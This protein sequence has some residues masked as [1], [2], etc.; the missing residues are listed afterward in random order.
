VKLSL[1]EIGK[2]VSAKNI[3]DLSELLFIE[4]VEFDS[5]KTRKGSLFIPLKGNR[6]GHN[7]IES[8]KE[9]EAAAAFWEI[10]KEEPKDFPV[11]VVD[12]VLSAFQKLASYY[13]EK[14]KPMVIAVTGSNG[15]TTTKDMLASMLSTTFRTYKTQG[16]YNN[17]IGLPYTVLSMPEET[18]KIVLEMG[19][20]HPGDIHLLSTLAKPD[21]AILTL[22]GESHLEFFGTRENIA[23]G[24]FEIT[25]G[26]NGEGVLLYPGDEPLL[27]EL[28]AHLPQAHFS[29]G[30]AEGDR[31][32]YTLLESGKHSSTFQTSFLSQPVTIPFPGEYNVKN[33]VVS[34]FVA[35][36][37][38][39][40]EQAILEDLSNVE[41]TRNRT[42]W[43]TSKA[44]AE[45]LSDVYNANPTAMGLVLDSFSE[46]KTAGKRIAV[47]GDMLEL[48]E[49]SAALHRAMSKHIQSEKIDEVYLVGSEMKFLYEELL[50][51][52]SEETL[53][54]FQKNELN[55]VV[56]LLNEQLEKGDILLI[57]ASNSIGLSEV[58]EQIKEK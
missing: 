3:E 21:Y 18:Q 39:V 55:A 32:R 4:N 2:A 46:M 19:M 54:L 40:S 1:F 44:G 33:A 52:Y 24:K 56:Q 48:G 58:V 23:K 7:F 26:L 47:L 14:T 8:V 45:I 38:G 42:E 9:N 51:S 29:F 11:I 17:E 16:N 53:R 25:D 5:R 22:I 41:L 43:I 31:V 10:G 28:V 20:D 57:K 35:K 34:A 50:S 15:K 27:T 12:D 49:T 37:I 6:D 36:S 30:K 13:L